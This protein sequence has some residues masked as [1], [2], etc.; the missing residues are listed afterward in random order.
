MVA[1]AEQAFGGVDILFNNAGVILP[2]DSGPEE[3]TEEVWDRTLAINLKSVFLGCHYGIPALERAGGGAIINTASIVAFL[4]S[5]PAQI[6]YT[7]SKGGV[8]ALTRDVA[9]L[10]ARR[11]I[12]VNAICPGVTRTPMA[13]GLV[14]ND[15][16]FLRRRE[17]IPM[18]R[19]AE[20][21]EVAALALF[22]ASA[23]ASYV[24]GQ[25]FAV[26]GGMIGA[27]LTPPDAQR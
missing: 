27:Y 10:L 22:L 1:T 12:R 23:E 13:E 14:E 4:G 24:T 15:A 9:V 7:A 8:V 20:P 5:C 19:M 2:G 11:N 26:D 17:H 18:G 3:T 6:A 16:A 21:E 25:A